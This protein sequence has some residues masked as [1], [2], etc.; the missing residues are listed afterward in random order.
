MLHHAVCNRGYL[1]RSISSF[2]RRVHVNLQLESNFLSVCCRSASFQTTTLLDLSKK[3][4][5]HKRNKKNTNLALIYNYTGY[6]ETRG[7]GG[8][9]IQSAE[10]FSCKGSLIKPISL[11]SCLHIP[12]V[13][14]SYHFGCI[15][16]ECA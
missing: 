1:Y 12:L 8:F 15:Y 14:V 10:D 13:L 11:F 2:T 4:E 7:G 5:T 16:C 6:N 9:L 3:K